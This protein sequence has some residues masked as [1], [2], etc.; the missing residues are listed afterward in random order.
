[1]IAH[2]DCRLLAVAFP[3]TWFDPATDLEYRY[4]SANYVA[5]VSLLCRLYSNYNCYV[6]PSVVD[7]LVVGVS[8][9][10]VSVV[11]V[12]VVDVLMVNAMVVDPSG[13][14]AA[15]VFAE[16]KLHLTTDVRSAI[17]HARNWISRCSVEAT[18]TADFD[19]N[20]RRAGKNPCNSTQSDKQTPTWE[21]FCLTRS[22]G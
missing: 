14:V 10:G 7:V 17:E 20:S 15:R 22:S 9:V 2:I 21:C 13:F 11:D 1:M 18:D 3:A 16:Y 6:L 19:Y 5:M 4:D 8:V 12:L